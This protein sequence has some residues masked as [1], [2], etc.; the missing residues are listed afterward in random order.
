VQ[1]RRLA[2]PTPVYRITADDSINVGLVGNDLAG[3]WKFL[4]GTK[5]VPIRREANERIPAHTQN[6][7]VVGNDLGRTAFLLLRDRRRISYKPKRSEY[8]DPGGTKQAEPKDNIGFLEASGTMIVDDE[9]AF[10]RVA[11]WEPGDV[12]IQVNLVAGAV[13][14]GEDRAKA[15]EGSVRRIFPR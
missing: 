14:P 8:V 15:F 13:H 3:I 9:A 7:Y 6:I 11:N 12:T 4:G 5:E 1:I 2:W 10:A